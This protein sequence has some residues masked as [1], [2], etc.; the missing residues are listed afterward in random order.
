MD[1]LLGEHVALGLVAEHGHWGWMIVKGRSGERLHVTCYIS[2]EMTQA[3]SGMAV[4][5]IHL[6]GVSGV[7]RSGSVLSE[8]V[9]KGKRFPSAA[10][11][12]TG[13]RK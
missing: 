13:D 7:S 8:V 4:S 2:C 12:Q 5:I 6:V 1:E 9:R 10:S 11:P 3:R